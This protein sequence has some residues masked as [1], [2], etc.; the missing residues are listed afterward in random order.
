MAE[1][2]FRPGTPCWLDLMTSDV[3]GAREFYGRL[4]GWEFQTGDEEKYGG[5]VMSLLNGQ[6]VAGIMGKQPEQAD[7]PD[8][9]S[10][11]LGVEDAAATLEAVSAHGGTVLMPAMDVPEQGVMAIIMDPGQATVGVWQP[12]GMSGF[13]LS[14]EPGAP[15]WHELFTANF[16]PTLDFYRTVFGWDVSMMSDTDE[17]RYATLGE[18][19][20]ASAGVMDASALV[21]AQMPPH[22]RVYFE[23]QDANAAA[24]LVAELGGRVL[25]GPED[26][27]YGRILTA[28]DPFG[29]VFLLA[30]NL[31]GW[32]G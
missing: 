13:G 7:M 18:G 29:A 10:T 21:P 24:E 5:Y 17:F 32:K 19:M 11:Y 27:P 4:L 25:D 28:Q 26:T 9:W 22:W 30:Q 1:T 14:G 16:G 8:V 20:D 15:Y 23:V 3:Q 31:G 6:P 12:T 2:T